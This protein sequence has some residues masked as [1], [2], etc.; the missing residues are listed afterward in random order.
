MATLTQTVRWDLRLQLRSFIYP[1]TV[2][3]TALICGFILVL[4]VQALPA[5]WA[6]F[7][8]FMDPALIGLSFVGAIVLMEKAE[9]T[10]F[11]LGVT[12]MRPATYVAAKTITLTLLAFAS[13]LV[14]AYVAA[15]RIELWRLLAALTLSSTFAVLVGLACVA[16]VPTM[17][18]LMITLL[19]VEIIILLPVLV[20]FAVLPE[21][22]TPVL[23]LIPSYAILVAITL[24]LEPVDVSVWKEIYAYGYLALWCALGWFWALREYTRNIVTEGR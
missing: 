17:N 15:D 6:A 1:A 22:L 13:G 12:P 9:G 21:T 5:D 11:A 19:W 23:A 24:S 4:P 8:V 3:S 7:F 2:V 20:H 10:I 16:R 14:V 18:K